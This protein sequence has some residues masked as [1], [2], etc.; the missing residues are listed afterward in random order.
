[1]PVTR[2]RAGG[3]ARLP[4]PDFRL[5]TRTTVDA[6]I[7]RTRNGTANKR[8]KKGSSV[9]IE[10]RRD[11]TVWTEIERSSSELDSRGD[12]SATD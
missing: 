10:S 4:S 6:T 12:S 2:K 3:A 9:W 8:R 11:R 1:M 7:Q 5:A